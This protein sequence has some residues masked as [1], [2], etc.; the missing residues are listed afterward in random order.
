VALA[1][2]SAFNEQKVLANTVV[3]GEVGLSG[4]IRSVSQAVLRINEAEKLGFKYCILP[5]NNCK[6]LNYNKKMELTPVSTL[7]E[8]KEIALKGGI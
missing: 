7:K 2:I 3:L 5:K 1:V 6:N 4:E 8:A